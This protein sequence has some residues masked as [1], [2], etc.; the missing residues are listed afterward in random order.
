MERIV[1][2]GN[3]SLLFQLAK[4]VGNADERPLRPYR[5]STPGGSNPPIVPIPQV[6]CS[7]MNVMGVSTINSSVLQIKKNEDFFEMDSRVGIIEMKPDLCNSPQIKRWNLSVYPLLRELRVG[8]RCLQY[9]KELKLTGF[10]NLNQ[11]TIGSNCFS[12]VENGALEVTGCNLLS[13]F[14][15]GS[16]SCPN[17]T[18][19]VMKKCDTLVEVQIGEECFANG[20]KT[21]FEG[22]L[23][24]P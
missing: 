4:R 3:S 18:S 24:L 14:K 16:F 13:S 2:D 10:I 6:S 1:K 9:V 23:S 5:G 21:V 11:V 17:W 20:F 19:C 12:K 8:D 15:M 7:L 22:E